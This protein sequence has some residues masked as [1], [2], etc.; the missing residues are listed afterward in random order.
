LPFTHVR[1]KILCSRPVLPNHTDE[2][3]VVG[4][5]AATGTTTWPA[6][7]PTAGSS[8]TASAS[9]WS[10]T[11]V[12]EGDPEGGA[13]GA[14]VRIAEVRPLVLGTAWR[15]LTFVVVRP[16]EGLEGSARSG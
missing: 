12:D 4:L 7:R 13:G 1:P 5:A 14:R 10:R 9:L 2:T 8:S 11:R 15:N 16:D 6:P 3:R